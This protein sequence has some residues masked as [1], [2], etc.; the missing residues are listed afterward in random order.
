MI[1]LET[2]LVFVGVTT[3]LAAVPGLTTF[4]YSRSLQFMAELWD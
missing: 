4:S 3:A 1:H 2:M